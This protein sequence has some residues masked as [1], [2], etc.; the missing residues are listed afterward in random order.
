MA[1]LKLK[2]FLKIFISNVSLSLNAELFEAV[3]QTAK[4]VTVLQQKDVR[5]TGKSQ[6]ILPDFV[7]LFAPHPCQM[8]MLCCLYPA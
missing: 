7:V 5:R 6:G 8:H 2:V 4:N 3:D 1:S